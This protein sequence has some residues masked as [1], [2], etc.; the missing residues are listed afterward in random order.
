[1]KRA[2]I[3][4][5][6]GARAAYQVGV[7]QALAKILPPETENPFPIICGTSAGAI[8]ALALATHPGIFRESVASLAN[9]WQNLTVGNVYRHG[10]YDLAKGLAL[11][12]LYIFNEGVG[13]QRHLSMLVIAS[14]WQL[15]CCCFPFADFAFVYMNEFNECIVL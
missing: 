4:S 5:G 8:N 6:G 1:M 7:L 14:L 13:R 12:G 3:L 10:W 9:I 2:L 11:L 15:L